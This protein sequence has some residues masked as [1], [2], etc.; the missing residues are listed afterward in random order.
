MRHAKRMSKRRILQ[1]SKPSKRPNLSA[2]VYERLRK[3][4][5]EYEYP[6]GTR[7]NEDELAY[8]LRVSR[9]PVRDALKQL[10]L[11]GLVARSPHQGVF[12][13]RLSPDEVLELL[14]LREVLEGLAARLAADRLSETDLEKLEGIF[15]EAEE[16][17]RMGRYADYLERATQI[18]D[19]LVASSGSQLLDR[20]MHN[21][22]DRIRF[23]RSQTIH[24]PGRA[25]SSLQEHL[26]LLEAL[27]QRDPDRSEAVN[28][29]RIRAIKRD[30][31]EAFRHSLV[32]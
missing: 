22:Y 24:L 8:R 2:S 23:V 15:R 9:T 1:R 32:F 5:L 19:L 13:K 12:V 11:E 3:A 6:P 20:V 16:L 21:L 26:E 7:L 18:H 28:R 30:V 4:I 29:A 14:D 25:A 10:E 17:N 27:R 31:L